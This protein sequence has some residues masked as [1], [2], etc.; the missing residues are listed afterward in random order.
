[1]HGQR[2]IK[3]CHFAH[4]KSHRDWPGI[5]RAPPRCKLNVFLN[6]AHKS[7]FGPRSQAT[8]NERLLGVRKDGTQINT[9]PVADIFGPNAKVNYV[10]HKI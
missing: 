8:R 3:Q 5:E 9:R 4:H 7:A 1:M 10:R 2:N 6:N